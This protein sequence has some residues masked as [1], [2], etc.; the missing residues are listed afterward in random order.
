MKSNN[1]IENLISK[2]FE[3]R[4]NYMKTKKKKKK[5]YNKEQEETQTHILK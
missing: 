4:D 5:T 3:L 1:R 2:Y